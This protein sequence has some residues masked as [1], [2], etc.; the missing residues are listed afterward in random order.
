MDYYAAFIGQITVAEFVGPF[1]GDIDKAIAAFVADW[2][3]S[4]DVPFGFDDV[5]Y[6]YCESQLSA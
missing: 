1:G 4:Y 6:E 3:W 2:P 5:V